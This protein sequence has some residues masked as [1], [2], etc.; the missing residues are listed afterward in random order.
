ML[1]EVIPILLEVLAHVIYGFVHGE[2]FVHR[3]RC[4]K[5]HIYFCFLGGLAFY[6]S[7]V[8]VYASP[9]EHAAAAV[10]RDFFF[11]LC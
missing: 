2:V 6:A 10:T 5:W 8:L 9:C 1:V 11:L 4:I 3:H 7:L